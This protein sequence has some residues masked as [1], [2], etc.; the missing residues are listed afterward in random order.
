MNHL[1]F[2]DFPNLVFVPFDQTTAPVF[3]MLNNSLTS[4]TY[5]HINLIPSQN[6]SETKI[7]SFVPKKKTTCLMDFNGWC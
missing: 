7:M 3:E 5:R 2:K 6:S 1:F 4:T